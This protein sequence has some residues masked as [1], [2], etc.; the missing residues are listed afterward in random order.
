MNL[1][2]VALTA[3]LSLSLSA[4]SQ[5]PGNEAPGKPPSSVTPP[6]GTFQGGDTIESCAVID[7]LPYSATG[8]TAGFVND[9]DELCPYDGSTAPDCV[10]CWEADFTGFVDIHTCESSYDTKLYVYENEYTP[11]DFH[12]CNDDSEDC[13]GPIYRSW[14]EAMPVTAGSTYFVVVDGYGGE[15]GDYLFNMY[16]AF[17]ALCDPFDCPP[18][19]FDEGEPD[20][21]DGFV[22]TTNIGCNGDPTI[23]QHPPLP[24]T[25]C[26]TSGNYNDNTW[27]DMDWFQFTLPPHAGI[28]VCLCAEFEAAVMLLPASCGGDMLDHAWGP[29]GIEMC[30]EHAWPP[31]SYYVVVTTAGWNGTPCGSRYWATVRAVG[32]STVEEASWGTIKAIYR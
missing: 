15:F 17:P 6:E 21:Y 10:Y 23:F 19:P 16:E 30:V 20:C 3:L 14:I 12:A 11:G 28:E 8:T 7:A 29:A 24:T 5:I 31:R 4:T 22:D 18:D 32:Y 9:Y 2:A 13:P 27:R 1:T 25:I 26:G